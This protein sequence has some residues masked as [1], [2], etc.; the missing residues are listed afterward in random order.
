ME[1]VKNM[2][3]NLLAR[4]LSADFDET[5]Y[6]SLLKRLK[7]YTEG[8]LTSILKKAHYP[9]KPGLIKK[10]SSLV[11]RTAVR[12]QYPALQGKMT[13]GLLF[14]SVKIRNSFYHTVFP[15]SDFKFV[16]QTK[17]FPIIQSST[18]E[19]LCVEANN[20][21]GR[22][23]KLANHELKLLDEVL[24]KEYQLNLRNVLEGFSVKAGLPFEHLAWIDLFPNK[25]NQRLINSTDYLIVCI[26]YSSKWEQLLR[27]L[28]NR[29]YVQD[30]LVVVEDR[31]QELMDF[32]K[33]TK[34]NYKIMNPG[35][36]KNHL[37]TINK[38]TYN[39]AYQTEFEAVFLK[40][41][42][43]I[44][45]QR[46][47]NYHRIEKVNK[48][49]LLLNHDNKDRLIHMR[50]KI[51]E[52][53]IRD[54]KTVEALAKLSKKMF[55]VLDEME[56]EM[57]RDCEAIFKGAPID[58]ALAVSRGALQTLYEKGSALIELERYSEALEVAQHLLEQ[59]FNKG[60]LLLLKHHERNEQPLLK[61]SLHAVHALPVNDR[62]AVE[63]KIRYRDQ[64]GLSIQQ[65]INL[66]L[67]VKD[68]EDPDIQ[69]LLGKYYEIKK[70]AQSAIDYYKKSLEAGNE[71]AGNHLLGLYQSQNN[72]SMPNLIYLGN[73]LNSE[74]NYLLGEKYL[75]LN[76][77]SKAIIHLTF[78]SMFIHKK[79]LL[80]LAQLYFQMR[81]FEM[82]IES[83]HTLLDHGIT[84]GRIME[85]LGICYYEKKDYQNAY[86][87][88]MAAKTGE[89]FYRIGNMYE[90]GYGRI[91]DINKALEYYRKGKDLGNQKSHTKYIKISTRLDEEKKAKEK[92]STKAYSSSTSYTR[93]SSSSSYKSSSS[94]FLTTA[95]CKA[96]GKEDNCEEILAFKAF[97]DDWLI[98]QAEGPSII[99][100]YYKIAPAIV[101]RINSEPNQLEIYHYI[102]N[103]YM[104]KGYSY[105]LL[106]D[107]QAAKQTYIEMVVELNNNYG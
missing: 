60:H 54:T 59:G 6:S 32:L 13:A 102:W 14:D 57:V 98:T 38:P 41:S 72:L 21:F 39:F 67:K 30:V 90:Q 49:L 45:R 70:N 29:Q 4:L 95:T 40:A 10:V 101:D 46:Q 88:L 35:Q 77:T 79:A 25:K 33:R 100:E 55:G 28:E 62:E 48:T 43:F 74:A 86:E 44:H 84:N 65:A 36:L 96:L 82:A 31:K 73:L 75:T 80:R 15:D 107:Y 12:L 89:S 16:L 103:K 9:N 71:Q 22:K 61:E 47:N 11:E 24:I 94:C 105:L 53:I 68:T 93:S 1:S 23:E 63:A 104:Q 76:N 20:V 78:A 97:R 18:S 37:K 69:F 87:K 81:N 42:A 52:E 50:N 34:L 92:S 56:Q 26:G 91:K 7:E 3:M 17:K 19:G 5:K 2:E 106:K 58:R 99:K 64:L 8:E 27:E 51:Q 83:M 66:S 85:T